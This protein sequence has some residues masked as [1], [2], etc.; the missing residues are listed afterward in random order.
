MLLIFGFV[1]VTAVAIGKMLE[2]RW[3]DPAPLG[4]M[5]EQWLAQ[6]RASRPV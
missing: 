3:R 6:H 1:T 5:S 2:A 4:Q